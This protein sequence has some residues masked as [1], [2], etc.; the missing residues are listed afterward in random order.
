MRRNA[1]M[2]T[3]AEIWVTMNLSRLKATSN[4][5]IYFRNCLLSLSNSNNSYATS[6]NA[7]KMSL[8]A[9]NTYLYF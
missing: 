6:T 3:Q 2:R 1:R 4:T 9:L 8:D 7:K 5:T